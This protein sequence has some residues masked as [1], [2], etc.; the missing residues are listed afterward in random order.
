V[1]GEIDW[2]WYDGKALEKR[3]IKK[4]VVES[5]HEMDNHGYEDTTRVAIDCSRWRKL[6]RVVTTGQTLT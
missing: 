1:I 2:V 6:D 3:A 5:G 4:Y